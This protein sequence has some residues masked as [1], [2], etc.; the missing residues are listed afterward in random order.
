MDIAEGCEKM[1]C[2]SVCMTT[3][4]GENYV[5]EQLDSILPQL[6]EQDELLISDDGSSDNTQEILKRYQANDPRIQVYF[7]HQ[8]GVLKNF[9]FILGKARNEIVFL[10]DQDDIWLPNKKETLLAYFAADPSVQVLMSD[11]QIVND[12]RQILVESFYDYRHCGTGVWKNIW[13]NTYIGC[14]MAVRREFLQKCLP[15]PRYLPMHDMWI[16]ILADM[17]QQARMIPEKLLFYRRHDQNVS[18]I[19]NQTSVGQKLIWRFFLLFY[20][21]RYHL[22]MKK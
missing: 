15:F 1:T 22:K 6:G 2:V 21:G 12:Q 8:L 17:H 16:G 19:S 9:E 5:S 4:N 10:S 14:A 20:L 13:K 7:N 18:N 11:A 3:Y